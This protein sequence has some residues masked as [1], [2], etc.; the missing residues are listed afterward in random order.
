MG[1]GPAGTGKTYLAVASLAVKKAFKAHGRED[2]PYVLRW[3]QGFRAFFRA[4][5]NVR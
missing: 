3:K 5:C 2:N 4:T 1:I